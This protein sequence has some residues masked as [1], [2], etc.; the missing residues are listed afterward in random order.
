MPVE[1]VSPDAVDADAMRKSL[2]DA[3]AKSSD[4]FDRY[5]AELSYVPGK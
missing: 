2:N 1:L 3:T 5:N 4:H